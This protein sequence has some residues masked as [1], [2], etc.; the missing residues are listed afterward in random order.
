M[1][2]ACRPL[3]WRYRLAVVQSI[4]VWRFRRAPRRFSA[5]G[6]PCP[7]VFLWRPKRADKA[8]RAPS[9]AALYVVARASHPCESCNQHTGG[10][11]VPLKSE[12]QTP[13]NGDACLEFNHNWQ[14]ICSAIDLRNDILPSNCLMHR[15]SSKFSRFLRVSACERAEQL[16]NESCYCR[17]RD[18]AVRGG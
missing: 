10:T 16:L 15:L 6:Q 11:P 3:P 17:K 14:W 8:V 7:R 5:R 13:L 12:N 2:L 9:V 4:S 18:C 1:C